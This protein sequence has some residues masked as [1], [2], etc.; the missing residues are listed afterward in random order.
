MLKIGYF[1]TFEEN[2]YKQKS[3]RLSKGFNVGGAG[4]EPATAWV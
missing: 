2:Y 1:S 3:L 4:L